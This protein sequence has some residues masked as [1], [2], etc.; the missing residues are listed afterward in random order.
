MGPTEI[1]LSPA[2]CQYLHWQQYKHRFR[3]A[4]I[5]FSFSVSIK[6]ALNF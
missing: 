6:F 3:E 1:G 5:L 2:D 4:K